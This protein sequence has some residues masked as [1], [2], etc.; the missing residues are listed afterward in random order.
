LDLQTLIID[1]EKNSLCRKG[2]G[3]FCVCLFLILTATFQVTAVAQSKMLLYKIGSEK[4]TVFEVDDEIRFKVKGS[5][6]FNKTTIVQFSDSSFF[7]EDYEVLINDIEKIDIR[8]KRPESRSLGNFGSFFIYAG[9][10]YAA[11]DVF[12][13]EVIQDLDNHDYTNTALISGSLIGTGVI[14]KT[15]NKGYFRVNKKKRIKIID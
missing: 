5:E 7:S 4:T 15:L 13:R 1:N 12:N 11:G 14:M 6:F 9:V 8:D 2:T 10:F 3:Y